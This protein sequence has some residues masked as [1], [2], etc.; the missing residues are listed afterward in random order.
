MS[1]EFNPNKNKWIPV[2]ALQ[3]EE[4]ECLKLASKISMFLFGLAENKCTIVRAL[5]L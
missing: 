5:G 2:Q 4:C 1:C 3:M